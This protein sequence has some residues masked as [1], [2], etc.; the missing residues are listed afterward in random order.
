MYVPKLPPCHI[1]LK[2]II[3]KVFLFLAG[4]EGLGKKTSIFRHSVTRKQSQCD[5]MFDS[6]ASPHLTSAEL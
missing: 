2:Y 1:I 5:L 3:L 6:D 4:P